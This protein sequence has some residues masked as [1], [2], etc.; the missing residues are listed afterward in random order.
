[1]SLA[2]IS[3]GLFNQINAM[4]LESSVSEEKEPSKENLMRQYKELV[5]CKKYCCETQVFDEDR[6]DLIQNYFLPKCNLLLKTTTDSDHQEI[7]VDV[8][9]IVDK[10]KQHAKT[11]W[12]INL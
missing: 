8:E 7:K 3:A 12:K 10:V 11:C 5:R 9:K 6:Y 2:L 4:N 1:M